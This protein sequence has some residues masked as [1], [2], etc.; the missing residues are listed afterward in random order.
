MLYKHISPYHSVPLWAGGKIQKDYLVEIKKDK[1]ERVCE[2]E[3]VGIDVAAPAASVRERVRGRWGPC[4]VCVLT[5][6]HHLLLPLQA[7]GPQD[8]GWQAAN[9]LRGIICAPLWIIVMGRQWWG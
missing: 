1:R 2:R 9:S 8:I 4:D 3:A 6:T 7:Q 5:I